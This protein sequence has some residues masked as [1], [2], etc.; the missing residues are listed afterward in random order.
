MELGP[1]G[2]D[3]IVCHY[4]ERDKEPTLGFDPIWFENGVIKTNGPTYTEQT[5]MY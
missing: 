4:Q 5:V 3:W 2:R 1:D